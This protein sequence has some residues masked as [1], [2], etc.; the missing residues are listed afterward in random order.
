MHTKKSNP[1][2]KISHRT[3]SHYE[4]VAQDFWEGTRDHDVTQNID[5]LLSALPREKSLEILDF[6]CGPGRDLHLFKKLGH[7]PT[8]L[9]GCAAFCAMATK[10]SGCQVLHQDFL[11]LDLPQKKFHGIF[12]NASL[13]HIPSSH[14]TT[15]LKQLGNSLKTGG[16][17]FSSN[18]RGSGEGWNGDRYGYYVELESYKAHLIDAGFKLLSHYYRPQGKPR[19]EQPWLAT[20]SQWSGE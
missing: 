10:Y 17:L 3:L 16:I 8:G 6:G 7:Q 12:A 1:L 14:F 19:N 11:K 18:P 4:S 15:V 9:D 20:I 5:A 13:F 2:E